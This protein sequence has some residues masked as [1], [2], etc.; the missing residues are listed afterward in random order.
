MPAENDLVL[1][2]ASKPTW[3]FGTWSN[4][5]GCSVGIGNDLVLSSG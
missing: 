4:Y 5:L 2:L 1:E 3:I